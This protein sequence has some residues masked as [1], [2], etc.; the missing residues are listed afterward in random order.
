M[1]YA[2]LVGDGMADEPVEKLQDK[3]PLEYART[4]SMDLIARQG[5]GGTVITVPR[6]LVASSDVAIL[7]LL[8]YDPVKY[9]SGRG[10]L[11]AASM[12]INLRE[13][14]IAFRC[15]LVAVEG[16]TLIDYSAGHI[17][18]KEANAL[19]R[20]INDKLGS[21]DIK[22]YPGVSYRHLMV[23]KYKDLPTLGGVRCVAPHDI[24]GQSIKKNLPRG[25]GSEF[26]REL[27]RK[28]FDLLDGHEINHIRRD[29]GENPGNMI[30]L[31]GQ[32]KVP[33]MPTFKEKFAVEGSVISAVDVV[34]GIAHYANLEVVEVPGATGYFDTNYQGKAEG[35]LQSLRK[36]DFVFIHV[37]APDEAGH[38]G[39]V[40]AKLTAIEDFDSKVVKTVLEGLKSFHEYRVLVLPDH[41]TPLRLRTHTR[42]PVPF[43]FFGTDVEADKMASFSESSASDGSIH[44]KEG[45][46]LMEHFLR[47]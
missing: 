22:F 38:M 43:A 25:K 31:W 30:W 39:D 8:G 29:L 44:L 10:P 18:N 15:N 42:G 27:M 32:G 37:E 13:D 17:S 26:L 6:G 47:K 11:E 36:K 19:I 23:V 45:W 2:V 1:K 5:K 35:A 7:S 41:P 21:S 34:K 24:I 16:D 28:S 12:G 14:E 40:R 9:Y 20:F 46:K 33:A 3:T 4:P